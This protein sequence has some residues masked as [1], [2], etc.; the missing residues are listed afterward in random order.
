MKLYIKH[1]I[2][3]DLKVGLIKD[4]WI[5]YNGVVIF[6]RNSDDEIK[7]QIFGAFLTAI[8]MF[9]TQVSTKGVEE[10][11]LQKMKFLIKRNQNLL[12]IV[13]APSKIK[14]KKMKKEINQIESAFLEKFTLE[15]LEKWDGDVSVF[16]SFKEVLDRSFTDT[17]NAFENDIW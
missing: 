12:F 5:I 7:N 6:K 17:V 15:F 4:I 13:N 10:F 16:D 1:D 9:A 2:S 11:E 8:D 14:P 3:G